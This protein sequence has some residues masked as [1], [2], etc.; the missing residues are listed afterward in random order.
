MRFKDKLEIEFPE[1]QVTLIDGENG[2]GK[3]SI[4]DAICVCLYSKTLRTSGTSASGFLNLSDLVNHS[5]S[6]ADIILEFENHGHAYVVSRKIGSGASAELIEDGETKAIGSKVTEYIRQ[7]SI[8]LDWDGFT[9]SSI[10]M[11]GQMSS[12]TELLP[13][14][15]KAAFKSLYGLDKY[16]DYDKMAKDKAD[17]C[18]Q[19]NSQLIEVNKILEADVEKI[20]KLIENIAK[21]SKKLKEWKNEEKTL[22]AEEKRLRKTKDKYEILNNKF[23]A[24]KQSKKNISDRKDELSKDI[25]KMKKNLGKL[26]DIVNTLPVLRVEY[27]GFKRTQSEL[28]SHKSRKARFDSLSSKFSKLLDDQKRESLAFKKASEKTNDARDAF[29]DLEKEIPSV[30][31]VRASSKTVTRLEK[32]LKRFEA[33]KTELITQ[34]RLYKNA[35]GDLKTRMDDLRGKTTCPV[36]LQTIDD[37]EKVLKHYSDELDNNRKLQDQLNRDLLDTKN[38]IREVNQQYEIAQLEKSDL[39][40]KRSKTNLL[41]KFGKDASIAERLKNS[42]G[43]T[44]SKINSGIEIQKQRI[45]NLNFDVKNYE[46]LERSLS[47]FTREKVVERFTDALSQSKQLPST[48]KNLDRAK[49]KSEQYLKLLQRLDMKLDSFGD[50]ERKYSLAK[51]DHQDSQDKL[52]RKRIEISE[53]KAQRYALRES[54]QELRKKQ[55]RLRVNRIEIKK[56]EERKLLLETLRSIFKSL[57]DVILARI[58]PQIEREGS[59]IINDLSDGEMTALNIGEQNL[60][61][62]ATTLGESRPIEYF[63][64]GQ[65]TRI[66]MALRIANS[67]L[68]TK[69]PQTEEHTF[70]TMETLFIDEGDF[71]NLDESGIKDTVNVIKSLTKEFN[72]VIIVSHIAMFREMFQGYTLHVAKSGEEESRVLTTII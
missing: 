16:E 28:H 37:P 72:R 8:G 18:S 50:I 71:G 52:S 46:G 15:R 45:S 42:L 44:V 54:I 33:K 61:I 26:Q 36:C 21:F 14:Q 55:N 17:A 70:A 56:T 40:S 20:P 60:A 30:Q 23:Q 1:G 3:T 69:L 32:S 12:L 9:K 38:R 13:S 41:S 62:S 29:A 11:Q 53:K 67:R 6:N 68:L 35:S 25:D 5:A 34:I 63:S 49:N 65:K 43:R 24:S 19:A 66:N 59:D 64:G 48:A 39:L 2:S 58:R 27:D 4:L 22:A 31:M 10:I 51:N 7:V 47:S 57:P